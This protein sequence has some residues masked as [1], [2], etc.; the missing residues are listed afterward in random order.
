MPDREELRLN[1]GA[2]ASPMPGYVNLDISTGTDV[3]ALPHDDNSVDEIRASHVLEHIPYFETVKTVKHWSDKLRPGGLLKIAVPDF[4]WLHENYANDTHPNWEHFLV[5]GQND[6]HDVHR[7]IFNRRKLEAIMQTV[8]L[9]EIC[10]WQSDFD[11]CS[12]LPVSLNLQGRKPEYT[13]DKLPNVHMVSSMPR[14]AFSDGFMSIA[15]A[16][17]QLC[18][19]FTKTS[20]VFWGQCLT[21]AMMDVLV[22]GDAEYILTVDYDSVFGPSDVKAL[23]RAAKRSNADAIFALQMKRES[24]F[25]LMTVLDD[26]GKPKSSLSLDDS[27]R[28]TI[29]VNTGHFGLTLIKCDAL[30]KLKHP[31]F[32]PHPAADG[33]WADGRMDEDIHFWKAWAEAG[34][35]LYQANRV[36]IGHL[37]L[38][39]TWPDQLWKARHDYLNDFYSR[40]KPAYAR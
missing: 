28:D 23:Y 27:T 18:M 22:R 24:D 20:G 12:A 11:D 2:G 39:I 26:D 38:M 7:A 8:G 30:R 21:R 19:P 35:T 34:N 33:T 6:Q 1:L 37:Q 3:R 31:W 5:G 13:F 16:S 25:A 9:E 29:R 32:L 36:K 14:L 15:V 4:D 10:I 17:Q 40:G